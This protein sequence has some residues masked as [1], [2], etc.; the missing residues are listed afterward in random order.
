MADCQSDAAIKRGYE[1]GLA[2]FG[3]QN[4]CC[5]LSCKAMS[6]C[7]GWKEYFAFKR[8]SFRR[9]FLLPWLFGR[10]RKG[11]GG[12]IC[13]RGIERG[14][15][16]GMSAL[17]APL[18]IADLRWDLGRRGAGRSVSTRHRMG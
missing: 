5:P 8:S 16:F 13:L 1:L 7:G 9:F 2:K 17:G 14:G 10:V 12:R 11:E 15:M 4:L 6:H 18:Y 3:V